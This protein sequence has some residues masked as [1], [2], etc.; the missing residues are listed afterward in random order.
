MCRCGTGRFRR[1]AI[2]VRSRPEVGDVKNSP[3]GSRT[4]TFA[5]VPVAPSN[6]LGVC[7][8][9]CQQDAL[10]GARISYTHQDLRPYD[11]DTIL[12]MPPSLHDW[13]DPEGLPAFLNDLADPTD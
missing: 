12:L 4:V 1:E 8:D 9:N 5:A 6:V 13:V 3:D 10:E 2:L 7:V 11:Q